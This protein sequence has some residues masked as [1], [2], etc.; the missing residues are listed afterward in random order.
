MLRFKNLEE[1]TIY[2][3]SIFSIMDVNYY[4]DQYEAYQTYVKLTI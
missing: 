1:E 2:F 4:D 3:I